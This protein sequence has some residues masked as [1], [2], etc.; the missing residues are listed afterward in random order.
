[1]HN[2]YATISTVTENRDFVAWLGPT[3]GP[4][5]VVEVGDFFR[6]QGDMGRDLGERATGEVDKFLEPGVEV[7]ALVGHG[8]LPEEHGWEI[9][10]RDCCWFVTPF[11]VRAEHVA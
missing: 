3:V 11:E 8:V 9:L 10:A 6:V 1:M 4:C 2:L 7:I 5:P